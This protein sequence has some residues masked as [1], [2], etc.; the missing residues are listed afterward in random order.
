[1]AQ[2]NGAGDGNAQPV[3]KRLARLVA[4][5]NPVQTGSASDEAERSAEQDHRLHLSRRAVWLAAS[6]FA[7]FVPID[8]FVTGYLIHAA[9]EA[10]A[11]VLV[12]LAALMLRDP[13]NLPTAQ[14]VATVAVALAIVVVIITGVA[15]DGVMVWLALFPPV[16]FYLGGLIRG[17]QLSAVFAVIVL[18]VLTGSILI[19]APV[20]FSWIAVLNAGGAL[21]GSTA[22]AFLYERSR[23][24]AQR[25]LAAAANTDLLTGVANRRG[26]AQGFETR[27]RLARRARQPLSV[28]VFDLDNLKPINDAKGHA[29]GDAAIRHVAAVVGAH[30]R[31]Q[32]QLGRIGGDEF[33][34]V[35][36]DTDLDGALTLAGKLRAAL[37]ERPLILGDGPLALTLSIGAAAAT[38]LDRIGFD[39][40]LAAADRRLYRVKQRGRDGQCGV[41]LPG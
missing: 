24:S 33:A 4:M 8:L 36:P 35:L 9:V 34:L 12:L 25:R 16:P 2:S 7:F 1:M 40:L 31:D 13:R 3:A 14:L 27:H 26:F 38:D 5:S 28:L 29:A 22:I 37:A 41:R 39:H 11:L 23:R 20:G 10:V 17:L 19:E 18:L 6:F 21:V 15:P 32:D 30:I